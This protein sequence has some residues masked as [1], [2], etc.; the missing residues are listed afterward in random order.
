MRS[1]KG[2]TWGWL[3]H[4]N[5]RRRVKMRIPVCSSPGHWW[6]T[7]WKRRHVRRRRRT[8]L[9]WPARCASLPHY[10]SRH[11]IPTNQTSRMISRA[12]FF[13]LF[14]Q[15]VHFWPFKPKI[16]TFSTFLSKFGFKRSKIVKICAKKMTNWSHHPKLSTILKFR[17]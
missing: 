7:R 14:W 8:S 3:F 6:S 13:T 12:I 10:R 11:L 5:R 4:R 1:F 2:P 17:P 15:K 9:S 16:H